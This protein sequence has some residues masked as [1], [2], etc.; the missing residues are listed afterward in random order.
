VSA[1]QDGHGVRGFAHVGI[2]VPELDT[3]AT[4]FGDRLGVEVQGP[5]DE[6]ELG[7]KILWVRVGGVLLEFVAPA[8]E[9]SRAAAAVA[10]GDTGV[11]HVAIEVEGLDSLLDELIAAGVPVR[12]TSPRRGSH[13]SRISFLDPAAT[14]GALIELMEHPKA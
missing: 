2:I 9:D 7:L 11:H 6:P 8:R 1:T 13:G 4:L 5:E 12:D 14:G 3:A 10:R